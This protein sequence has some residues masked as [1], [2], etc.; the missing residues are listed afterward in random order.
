VAA[1]LAEVIQCRTVSMDPNAPAC[2]EDANNLPADEVNPF[3]ELHEI[4]IKNYPLV[5]RNL[6]MERI[7]DYSLL[8][9]WPGSSPHLPG[10]LFAA[11]QDVVPVDETSLDQWDYPP[12]AGAIADGFVWGRGSMDIKNQLIALLEA[13]EY[14]LRDGCQPVR[15]VYLAFGHDEEIGGYNGAMAISALLAERGV[16]LGALVDEGSGILKEGLP[17]FGIPL[18]MVGTAEKGH[19]TLELSVDMP[20]GHSSVP[21]AQ[22]GIGILARA[23]TRLESSPIAARLD[24][25]KPV[26]KVLAPKSP[27]LNRLAFTNLWL[28]GNTVKSELI[29]MPQTNALM[30]TTM[31]VTMIEGGIKDNILP[32]HTT[33]KV[34]IRLFPG[35]TVQSVVN[36]V[37][38]VVDDQRVIISEPKNGRPASPLSP[39]DSPAYALLRDTIN[40]M[41]G[42]IPVTPLLVTGATDA[43]HYASICSNIYRFTPVI[44]GKADANRVHGI[45]ERISLENLEGMVQ[46]FILLIQNWSKANAL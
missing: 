1:H 36:H 33:A 14:L 20:P 46:F 37:R 39:T 32:P 41:F 38:R 21:T 17:G 5:S 40:Q 23:I 42:D 19:L 22:T 25:V 34:N 24:Q 9:T 4:L 6:V 31:A 11:H 10:V 3:I 12:F 29:K 8:F 2:A 7:N 18:A 13:V 27:F 35:D 45:G 16:Q 26:L 28:F 44:T 15:T 43:R 30:R